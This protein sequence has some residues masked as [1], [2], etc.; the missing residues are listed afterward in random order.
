MRAELLEQGGPELWAQFM[1]ELRHVHLGTGAEPVAPTV[2]TRL[3]QAYAA[4]VAG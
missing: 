1:D 2:S 4:V 3:Q